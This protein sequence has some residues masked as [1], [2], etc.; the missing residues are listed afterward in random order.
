M[1]MPLLSAQTMPILSIDWTLVIQLCNTFILFLLLKKFLFKPVK[2]MIDAREA[3]V[4]GLYADANNAKEEALRM[5]EEYTQ[6]LAGAKEEAG[7]IVKDACQKAQRRSDEIVLE[8]QNKASAMLSKAEAEIA[9]EKKKA[10]NEIKDEI[11][12]IA[13]MIAAKVVEKDIDQ[14]DHEKL[15]EEFIDGV[16]E[17]SWK[18]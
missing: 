18:A 2:A 1:F 14:K 9:Q 3:E 10:F 11:S 13:I 8:A 6:S 17:A 15:I 12:D 16:G 4:T 7:Q 5:K